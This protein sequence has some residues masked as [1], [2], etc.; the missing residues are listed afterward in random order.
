MGIMMGYRLSRLQSAL[1][2]VRP[3]R[4]GRRPRSAA[5]RDSWLWAVGLGRWLGPSRCVTVMVTVPRPGTDS[6]ADGLRLLLRLGQSR[7]TVTITGCWNEF[8][9]RS[10]PAARPRRRIIGSS[11]ESSDHLKISTPSKS[12]TQLYV[13][14][15][16]KQPKFYCFKTFNYGRE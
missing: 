14:F 1:R 3:C 2:W 12:D 15:Q 4:R 13:L 5:A 8:E 7:R 10:K 11:D 6:R 16:V 9:S